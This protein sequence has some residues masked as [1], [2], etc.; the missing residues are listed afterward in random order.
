LAKDL[1]KGRRV[2]KKRT[3]TNVT[4]QRA[5]SILE[6]HFATLP[7]HEEIKARKELHK[8]ATAV[9]RRTRGKASR[10]RRTAENRRSRKNCISS[11]SVP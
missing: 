11:L 3:K 8:L 4:V 5:T 10:S 9:S 2:K 6:E 1:Q 7:K